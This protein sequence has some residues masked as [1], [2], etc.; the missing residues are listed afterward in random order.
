MNTHSFSMFKNL[1]VLGTMLLLLLASSCNYV[2]GVYYAYPDKKDAVRNHKSYIEAAEKPFS[3]YKKTVDRDYGAS[4]IVDDWTKEDAAKKTLRQLALDHATSALMIIKNDSI[5]LED[6]YKETNEATLFTSFSI[7]KSY[8]SVLIGIA[9]DE[10][11]LESVTQKMIDFIPELKSIEG[12]EAIHILHLLNQTSGLKSNIFLDSKIYYGKKIWDVIPQLSIDKKAGTFQKYQNINAQL[13]GI[14]LYR[15]TGK[16]AAQYLEEKIW[17]NIGTES[18]AFWNAFEDDTIEK[19]FCCLNATARD[20]ARFGRLMLNKGNWNGKQI[21]SENWVDSI[22]KRDTSQGSSWAYN[23]SWFMG[24]K[25]YGDFMA[26]GLYRQMIYICPL[27]NVIIVRFADR[28][29][30]F[31]EEKARWARV[32]REIVDQL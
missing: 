31:R 6:Y 11:H 3:F 7:A 30:K 27:K 4:L 16:T 13:L 10:G 23:K 24:L 9:I 5:L 1:L 12:M 17:K 32:C 20:Y 21:I 25:Q 2:R 19:T 8:L 28:E 29:D 26:V 15:A 22:T 14:I 18:T